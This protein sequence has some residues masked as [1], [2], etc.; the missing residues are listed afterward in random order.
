MKKSSLPLHFVKNDFELIKIICHE[1]ASEC[2][3]V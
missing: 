2:E 1:N 3:W